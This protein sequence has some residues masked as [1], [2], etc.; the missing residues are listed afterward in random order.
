MVVR[1][2]RM[3]TI[4]LSDHT[5]WEGLKTK[6]PFYGA[7]L[8]F[9]LGVA[10]PT[11]APAQSAGS[12]AYNFLKEA[13][14]Q[15]LP[16]SACDVLDENN[17]INIFRASQVMFMNKYCGSGMIEQSKQLLQNGVALDDYR[18]RQVLQAMGQL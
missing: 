4:T 14:C 12:Y 15:L 9:L 1:I 7:A 10:T 11:P 16:F 5:R 6:K 3:R 2:E 8:I 13:G 18:C 17:A